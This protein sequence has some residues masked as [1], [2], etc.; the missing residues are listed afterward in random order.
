MMHEKK[1]RLA[2]VG[3]LWLALAL[4]S[5]HLFTLP[6][7]L[8]GFLIGMAIVCMILSMLPDKTLEKLKRW[9]QHG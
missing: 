9:K 5:G 8:E 6:D 1:R 4:S 3:A 7:F 2:G